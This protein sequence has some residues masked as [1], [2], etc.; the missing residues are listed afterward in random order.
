MLLLVHLNRQVVS[1][2][3]R[4][5]GVEGALVLGSFELRPPQPP[6]QI[7]Y[8]EGF[9]SLLSMGLLAL[10]LSVV[11]HCLLAM[12]LAEAHISQLEGGRV[13]LKGA[14]EQA[15]SDPLSPPQLAPPLS[16]PTTTVCEVEMGDESRRV[17]LSSA[18]TYLCVDA[19]GQQLL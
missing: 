9:V 11:S 13:S 6:P 8:V 18:V 10:P 19:E 16:H 14:S 7:I 2:P 15:K 4:L 5:A 3:L 1:G 12:L 17:F